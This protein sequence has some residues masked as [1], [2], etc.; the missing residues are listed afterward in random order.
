[1]RLDR[2]ASFP[3]REWAPAAFVSALVLIGGARLIVL[4]TQQR[5]AE[6]REA[7]AHAALPGASVPTVV[8]PPSI[9]GGETIDRTAPRPLR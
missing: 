8:A 2:V 7:A 1:M 6:N 3:W 4:S 9:V 5:I